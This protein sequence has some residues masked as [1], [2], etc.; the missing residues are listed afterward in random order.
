MGSFIYGYSG[1]HLGIELGLSYDG[2]IIA[3]S[4]HAN[5]GHARVY[6]YNGSLESFYQLQISK[7]LKKFKESLGAFGELVNGALHTLSLTLFD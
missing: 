7:T 3:M 2:N 5:N 4:G 6:Q 1:S